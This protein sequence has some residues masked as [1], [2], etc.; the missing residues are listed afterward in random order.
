[1]A[2]A[3]S[4]NLPT[5]ILA[6]MTDLLDALHALRPLWPAV[7]GAELTANTGLGL[8]VWG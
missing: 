1:M 4:A 6:G 8:I 5:C 7:A 3:T 2:S